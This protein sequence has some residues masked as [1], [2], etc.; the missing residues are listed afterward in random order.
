MK[1]PWFDY[2]QISPFRDKH[3]VIIGG[4][5]AGCQMAWHLCQRDWQVTLIERHEKLATESSGNA[6]GVISPKVTAKTSPGESFYIDAFNYTLAQLASLKEQGKE[7]D[8]NPCGVIQLAHNEREKK[9]WQALEKRGFNKDFLQT[10]RHAETDKIAGIKTHHRAIWFPGAGWIKPRKFCM[11]LSSHS[12]CNLIT[13]KEALHVQRHETNWHIKDAK[14]NTI[15]SAEVV[16]IANGKD[17]QKF[18]Q[19]A[20]LPGIPVLGQTSCTKAT[21]YSGKLKTVIGHEGYL[22]PA[23][24]SDDA[25]IK[26]HVFGAT[27]ERQFNSIKCKEPANRTNIEQLVK[28][29]PELVDLK[30]VTNS[31]HAAVRFTTPDRFPYAGALP[32]TDFYQQNYADLHLGR[33]WKK[34][35]PAKY[36]SGLFVIGGFGSR[37]LTT[38]GLCASVLTKLIDNPSRITTDDQMLLNSLHPARFIIKKLKKPGTK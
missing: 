18:E 14:H 1:T 23:F 34:Y 37:G 10:L 26:Q 8:W 7:C 38:S 33:H 21:D 22:T 5:I 31:S 12:G 13:H 4:G 9:R 35:P 32:H 20:F 2:S 19:A 28:Y 25:E 15:A 24:Q 11:Q 16:I 36:Q 3:A 29:L 30:K 17:I 27:F 6:A